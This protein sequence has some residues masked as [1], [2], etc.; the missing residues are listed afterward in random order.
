MNAMMQVVHA[1]VVVAGVRLSEMRAARGVADAL[2]VEGAATLTVPF[3]V[4]AK[5]QQ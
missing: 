5:A 3:R 4:P 2:A 1:S